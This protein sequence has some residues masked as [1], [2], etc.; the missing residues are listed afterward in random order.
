MPW[1]AIPYPERDTFRTLLETF[2]VG[3]VPLAILL[4]PQGQV[5]EKEAIF[6]IMA[7]QDGLFFPYPKRPLREI[8]GNALINRDG[9]VV[10]GSIFHD[11]HLR[12]WYKT[13]GRLDARPVIEQVVRA[14][15]HEIEILF[16][17]EEVDCAKVLP[18][19][20]TMLSLM[21]PV[22]I[23]LQPRALQLLHARENHHGL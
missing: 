7:D 5:V 23:A 19:F 16:C 21:H 1:L 14:Q 11:K 3:D 9:T 10:D 18:Y 2:E 15:G 6:S 17:S 8:L 22:E 4:D 12:L 20:Q 13:N